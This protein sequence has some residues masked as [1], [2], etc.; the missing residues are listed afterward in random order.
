MKPWRE[1]LPGGWAVKT[2]GTRVL[3]RARSEKPPEP[4]GPSGFSRRNLASSVLA[5]QGRDGSH[6]NVYGQPY[7]LQ[8]WRE[9]TLGTPLAC[10]SSTKS[11][12]MI[13]APR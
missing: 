2:T 8:E 13:F 11:R 1:R 3:E 9:P 7:R 6:R 12:T 10:E 5:C 4:E